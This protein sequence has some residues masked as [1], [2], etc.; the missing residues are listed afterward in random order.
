MEKNKY[1]TPI[2]VIVAVLVIAGGYFAWQ[3]YQRERAVRQLVGGLE[4]AF[5]GKDVGDLAKLAEEAS[6]YVEESG[7]GDEGVQ[8]DPY[9]EAEEIT[10]GNALVEKANSGIK[11]MLEEIFGGAKLTYYLSN[12]VGTD[13][14]SGSVVFT[15]KRPFG[16]GDASKLTEAIT[17][18]GYQITTSSQSDGGLSVLASK[19]GGQYTFG[20]DKDSQE[21]TVVIFN[22]AAFGGNQ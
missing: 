20:A 16:S 22:T 9:F 1:L 17:G 19:N 5:A 10:T 6:K 7:I 13:E 2:I 3:R 8:T 18:A 14:S 4:N 12:I 21:I 11:P 15:V